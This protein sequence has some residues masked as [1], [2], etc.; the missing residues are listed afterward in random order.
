M[1]KQLIK[2]DPAHAYDVIDRNVRE[3]DVWL[4]KWPEWKETVLDWKNK[5]PAYTLIIDGEVVGSGGVVLMGYGRGEAWLL[6]SSLFYKYKLTS[7][8]FIKKLFLEILES[9]DLKRVQATVDVTHL[10]AMR[11][12][13]IFGLEYEGTLRHY[14]PAGQDLAMFGRIRL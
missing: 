3:Q 8:R 10:K 1:N 2:F 12:A 13:D 4:S 5:W 11:F 6:L 14:G 7:I 9:H